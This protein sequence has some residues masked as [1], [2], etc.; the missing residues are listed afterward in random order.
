MS[1]PPLNPANTLDPMSPGLLGLSSVQMLSLNSA[2]QAN[3][4]DTGPLFGI[5]LGMWNPIVQLAQAPRPVLMPLK[6]PQ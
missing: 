4:Q 1:D 2:S 6:T 5:L 3:S